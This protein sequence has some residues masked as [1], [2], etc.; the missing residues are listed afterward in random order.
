MMSYSRKPWIFPKVK[1]YCQIQTVQALIA[2][3]NHIKKL[4]T[5]PT[6]KFFLLTATVIHYTPS[7]S[8]TSYQLLQQCTIHPPN[9]SL[10]PINCHSNKLYTLPIRHFLST[11][12]AMHYTP[13]K[14]VTSSCQLSQLCTIHPPN[15]SLSIN[16]HCNELYTLPTCHSLLSIVTVIHY[17]PS[18]PVTSSYQMS[19]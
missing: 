19:Q 3:H 16:C 6:F 8:V 5:L 4:N 12:K 1:I 13:S 7:Q 14:P 11:V 10:P 17:T 15:L 2:I 18:K 9:L